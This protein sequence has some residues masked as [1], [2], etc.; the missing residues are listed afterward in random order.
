MTTDVYIV[1]TS[2]TPFGRHFDQ[3]V[4]GL[5]GAAVEAL[6]EAC[7]ARPADID[8]A[9]F[10]NTTWSPLE[11]QH[12]VGGQIALRELGVEGVP[13]FNVENACASGATALHLAVNYVRAGQ[14]DVALAVGVE[15]M[16]IGDKA[17]TMS[18]FD[19]AYDVSRPDLL[20]QTLAEPGAG[21]V[22]GTRSVFMDIYA[23][24]ARR[25]MREFGTTQEQIAAVAAKNHTHAAENERAFYRR[26]LTVDEVLRD[27]ALAYPLT[28]PMCS[29]LTD[30]AAAVLIASETGI[31][32]LRAEAD[33]RI[34]ASSVATGSD[35]SPSDWDRHVTS[36]AAARAYRQAGVA[37]D[38]VSVAEVHDATAFAEILISERLG[39][40]AP[41]HG[42][43]D[44]AAGRTSIGGD[45]TINPSGGLESKG[46]PL[47]ATGLAQVH[48]LVDQL[49]GRAGAR[50]VAHATIALAENGGGF[51]RGEEAVAVVTILA[52]S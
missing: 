46:H 14:C 21:D 33:V 38:E 5:C 18:V 8:A 34:L 35:R 2:M 29:P 25:Y 43:S 12:M 22:M 13:V 11:G 3:S 45:I 20:E 16:N 30:G 48:E 7:A 49:R 10:A 4:V 52:R 19:G 47:G 28:V 17:K 1:E 42:G 24:L 26:P 32:R 36:T 40:C 27:R 41:G 23:A 6:F 15:K 39:L 37:P 50:Q 9:F 44:A 31:A 51:H